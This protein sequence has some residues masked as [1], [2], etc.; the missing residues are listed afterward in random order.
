[1]TTALTKKGM[2]QSTS[3]NWV[4]GKKI[5][6]KTNMTAQGVKNYQLLMNLGVG[7]KLVSAD[8][9]KGIIEMEGGHT[10]HAIVKNKI[11]GK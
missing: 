2:N 7:V 10:I 11:V 4:D 6:T 1:M 5:Y 8:L 9:N 3:S